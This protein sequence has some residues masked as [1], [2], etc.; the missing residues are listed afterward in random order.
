MIQTIEYTT[1]VNKVTVI[2]QVDY[3]GTY[4][5]IEAVYTPHDK[6][7]NIKGLLTPAAKHKLHEQ[8]QLKISDLDGSVDPMIAPNLMKYLVI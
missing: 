4:G 8:L 5:E 3:S 1:V 6:I 2:V 7:T